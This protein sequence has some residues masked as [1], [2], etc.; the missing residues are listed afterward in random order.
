MSEMN[1]KVDE[2]ISKAKKWQEEYNKLRLIAQNN[3]LIEEIKWGVPCYTYRNSNVILIHGFKD[4]CAILFVK[5]ALLKD[6]KGFLIQ[7]TA[8]VQAGRQIRFKNVQEI[9]EIESILKAYINEAIDIE[10]SGLKVQFKSELELIYPD[11]F[12]IKLDEIPE[13][14]IA[15]D[16]LT[17]GRK[18]AYNLFF[19]APKQAKTRL[20]RVENLMHKILEGKGLND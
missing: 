11:E 19:S 4:Y 10:K 16:A 13:L 1:P 12:Q 15:F 14:K 2:F 3:Q 8:N 6:E 5:G 17:P 7:Q 9:I 18:R 20:T